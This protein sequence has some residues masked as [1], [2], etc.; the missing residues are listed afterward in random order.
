MRTQA[1]WPQLAYANL[2]GLHS[3]TL[4]ARNA[5]AAYT[6]QIQRHRDRGTVWRD[7]VLKA[8]GSSSP[9]TGFH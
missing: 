7:H 5:L 3:D 6:G 1:T 9:S 2:G 4:P 8:G